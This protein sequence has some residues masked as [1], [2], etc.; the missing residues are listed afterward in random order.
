MEYLAVTAFVCTFFAGLF[1]FFVGFNM[2]HTTQDTI[3]QK[4]I[5]QRGYGEWC[6]ARDRVVFKSECVLS[7]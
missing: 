4:E 7:E 2:G 1:G 3:W 6:P 5:F